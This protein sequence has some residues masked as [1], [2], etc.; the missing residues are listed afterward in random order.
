[1]F[2]ATATR[3]PGLGAYPLPYVGR[4][5]FVLGKPTTAASDS[6]ALCATVFAIGTGHHPFGDD[7]FEAMNRIMRDAPSP[8]PG[9]LAVGEVLR[10][11]LSGDPSTRPSAAELA[12]AFADLAA[13]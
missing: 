12:A 6:F 1:M 9:S 7:T 11:G 2:I 3:L 4:D 10:R 5:E 13:S 8:W